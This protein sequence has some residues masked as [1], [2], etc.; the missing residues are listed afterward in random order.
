MLSSHVNAITTVCRAQHFS[1]PRWKYTSARLL[2]E[3]S[4]MAIKRGHH[5]TTVDQRSF[6]TVNQLPVSE[7]KAQISIKVYQ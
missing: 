1:Y 5:V 7:G 2:L 4:D 3:A 6:S